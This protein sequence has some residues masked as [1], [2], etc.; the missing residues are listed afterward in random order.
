MIREANIN[1]LNQVL[2]LYLSLHETNIPEY[3]IHL[4][5]TW[6]QIIGDPNHHLIVCE[7]A[8]KI[9]SSCVCYGNNS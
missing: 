4:R 7:V 5:N 3:S 6:Q 1:D 2:A 9:V 8:G